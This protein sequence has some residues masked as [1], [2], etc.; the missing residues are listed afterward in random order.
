[1]G[2]N[3]DSC[4]FYGQAQKSSR[5]LCISTYGVGVNNVGTELHEI[6]LWLQARLVC[7]EVLATNVLV[8]HRC[9]RS[10]GLLGSPCVRSFSTFIVA[11]D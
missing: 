5:V 7:S 2:S 6:D 4:I 1:M 3:Q 9:K 10:I 11:V 8:S